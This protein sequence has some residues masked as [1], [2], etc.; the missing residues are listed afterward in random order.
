M[1]LA[2][3]MNPD[4][5]SMSHSPQKEKKEAAILKSGELLPKSLGSPRSGYGQKPLERRRDLI[6]RF[7]FKFSDLFVSITLAKIDE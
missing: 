3:A 5:W 7:G 2:N 4:K 6:S 1:L